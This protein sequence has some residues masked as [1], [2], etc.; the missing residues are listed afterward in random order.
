MKQN[1]HKGSMILLITLICV[2]ACKKSV[3]Q[4]NAVTVATVQH[5]TTLAAPTVPYPVTPVPECDFAPFYGDSII[6]PQ[7][8]NSGDYYVSPQNNQGVQGTYLSWPAG[9]DM[10]AKTGAIDLTQSQTGQRY[11]VAFVKTG[12][13]D[14]CLAPLIVAGAAY[15][16]SVYVLSISDTTSQ[17]YFNANPTEPSPC[18]NNQGPGCQF[19]YN[20]YAR[21]QGIVVDQKTGYINL[22]QTMRNSPFGLI[23]LNGT[24][25]YTTIYY[26]LNDNSNFAPQ[27][28][29]LQLMYYNHRSAVPGG[30]VASITQ[31]LISTLQ[32]LLISKSTSPRPPLIIIVRDNE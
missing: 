11:S 23:P 9:L 8:S 29:Q 6:Y 27:N 30:L 21:N 26:K 12:T 5:D 32:D 31:N 18:E 16:D 19:D 28:I 7:P 4:P 13:T 24:T 3:N 1:L 15:M 20:N 17:P 22:Q 2:I 25:I 14:T 10:N